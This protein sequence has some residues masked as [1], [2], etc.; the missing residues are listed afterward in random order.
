MVAV[1]LLQ[2]GVH[3][4]SVLPGQ[5]VFPHS[6][7]CRILLSFLTGLMAVLLLTLC[8]RD[9]AEQ[10]SVD[11]A[12]RAVTRAEVVVIVVDGSEGVTQ[13][14]RSHTSYPVLTLL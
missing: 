5:L 12:M 1:W 8:G 10:L 14:A 6:A 2:N 9:G 4:I 11:R 7:P 13:Q 3:A